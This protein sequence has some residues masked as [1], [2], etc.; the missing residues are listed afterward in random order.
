MSEKKLNSKAGLSLLTEISPACK[1]IVKSTKQS[2]GQLVLP[3]F[4][5][6]LVFQ[7]HKEGLNGVKSRY[8]RWLQ[9]IMKNL[10]SIHLPKQNG[11]AKC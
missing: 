5:S 6:S 3:T 4:T 11:L 9:F 2:Y 1:S 8:A 7:S 10:E